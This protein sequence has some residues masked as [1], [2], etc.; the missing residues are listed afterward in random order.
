MGRPSTISI[1]VEHGEE[2]EI[3]AVRVGGEVVKVLE[4]V[5]HL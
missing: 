4:G 3:S 1:D 2:E 5:V